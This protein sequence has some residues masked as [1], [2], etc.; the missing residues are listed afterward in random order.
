MRDTGGLAL[1]DPATAADEGVAAANDPAGGAGVLG[2]AAGVPIYYD[3]EGYSTRSPA[4]TKVV[5]TFL[6]VRVTRLHA[7]GFLAGVYGSAA[8]TIRDLV[9]SEGTNTG[10]DAVWIADWNGNVGV[11]GDPYVSDD[12]WPAHQRVHQYRGGHRES[13]GGITVSI[14]S[15]SVDAPVVGPGGVAGLPPPSPA[16]GGSASTTDVATSVTW[17]STALPAGATIAATAGALPTTID[18]FAAGS[19][20]VQVTATTAKGAPIRRF[21]APVIVIFHSP[22]SGVVPAYSADGTT[23][24]AQQTTPAADGSLSMTITAPGSVGLLRDVTAPTRPAGFAGRLQRARL[25]LTWSSSS[26]NSGSIASYEID[27]AGHLLAT[28]SGG[29]TEAAVRGLSQTGSSSFRIAAI[30]AA[31]NR[32]PLSSTVVVAPRHRPSATPHAI[33]NWAFQLLAWQQAG[34]AGPRP[35]AP[36]RLP[37]WYWRWQTWRLQRLRVLFSPVSRP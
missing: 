16:Q 4:C 9:P 8:S 5:Q 19:Y 34:R 37:A 35:R 11:F 32:S 36:K 18:G 33:P 23:W 1:I 27:L 13:Y 2:I 21:S 12:H 17:S 29:A 24:Q 30:D 14:D 26:D 31:G 15:D 28:A 25:L 6:A 10:P 20:V 7:D 3:M 22:G